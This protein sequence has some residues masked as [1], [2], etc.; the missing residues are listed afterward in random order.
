MQSGGSAGNGAIAPKTQI[1]I[2]SIKTLFI[3]FK[4]SNKN[5]PIYLEVVMS[6]EVASFLCSATVNTKFIV[7]NI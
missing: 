7:F 5:I 3:H 2:N 4:I 6:D 1:K